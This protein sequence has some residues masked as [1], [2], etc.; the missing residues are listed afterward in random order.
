MATP[1]TPIYLE[2][3]GK[4][5]RSELKK[6]YKRFDLG[7]TKGKSTYDLRRAIRVYLKKDYITCKKHGVF[8]FKPD[9]CNEKN[10]VSLDSCFY[11]RLECKLYTDDERVY[12]VA[13]D[14][15]RIGRMDGA[16][17]KEMMDDEDGFVVYEMYENGYKMGV[18][19][20]EEKERKKS[21]K[22]ETGKKYWKESVK[23]KMRCSILVD[24]EVD[25]QTDE[26][27]V[28]KRWDHDNIE[29]ICDDILKDFQEYFDLFTAGAEFRGVYKDGK[30]CIF[31]YMVEDT[32][33]CGE[34]DYDN[35]QY[36]VYMDLMEYKYRVLAKE[37]FREHRE[38]FIESLRKDWR[39][40]RY[41]LLLKGED[42]SDEMM[43]L[44]KDLE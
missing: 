10:R 27:R 43:K 7:G 44:L 41:V 31:S 11:C 24:L 30:S 4:L 1:T 3:V 22:E 33:N 34:N 8:V 29:V 26:K 39:D 23:K 20:R 40:T 17:G 16:E 21:E 28:L 36:M 5:T 15:F 37:Y 35:N 42:V 32:R 9:S 25:C 18:L 14:A 38:G 19:E 12:D 13:Y 2:D 6:C